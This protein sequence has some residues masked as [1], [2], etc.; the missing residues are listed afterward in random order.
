MLG[1][2]IDDILVVKVT[3]ARANHLRL[4]GNCGRDYSVVVGV[5]T[6]CGDGRR[7]QRRQL[8]D[9]LQIGNVL[10]N[11]S[12]TQTMHGAETWIRER[13]GQFFEQSRRSYEHMRRKRE[14][15]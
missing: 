9:R 13:S 3:V 10:T 4:A 1:A 14:Q 5:A 7:R 12:V 2:K 15:L 6:D 11:L 8:G